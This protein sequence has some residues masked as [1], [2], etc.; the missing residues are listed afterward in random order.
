MKC[1]SLKLESEGKIRLST[2][3]KVINSSKTISFNKLSPT[4]HCPNS[5]L[6]LGILKERA[7]INHPAGAPHEIPHTK[8][9]ASG[10][11]YT[12]SSV[13][14]TTKGRKN[15]SDVP[16]FDEENLQAQLSHFEEFTKNARTAGALW[17]VSYT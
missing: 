17:T 5:S 10:F 1:T 16:G 7:K 6:P 15:L 12:Q 8:V 11:W 9:E 2:L 14:Q 4:R 3:T 13:N